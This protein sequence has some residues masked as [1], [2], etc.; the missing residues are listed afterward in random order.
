METKNNKFKMYLDQGQSKGIEINKYKI[1][2]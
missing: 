2:C 1:S